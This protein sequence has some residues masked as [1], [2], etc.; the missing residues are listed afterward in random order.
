V[1]LTLPPGDYSGAF[2]VADAA[3]ASLAE[4]SLPIHVSDR[5]KPLAVSS[6]VLA[7]TPQRA[8]GGAFD[9]GALGLVPRADQVFSRSESLWYA[10]EVANPSDPKTVAVEV[11][12]RSGAKALGATR[13]A[14]EPQP[15][16]A[17]RYVFAREMPLAG[18]EPGD[19]SLYVTVRDAGG[20]SQ[21]R[22]ADFRIVP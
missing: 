10:G 7:P 8:A 17:G 14:L 4:A 11:L 5:A 9:I 19:Y 12:L 13:I 21:V 1:G 16:A 3:G 6:M 2:A 20:A 22:R 15:V 18:F